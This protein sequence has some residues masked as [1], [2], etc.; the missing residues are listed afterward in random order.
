VM[1]RGR[2]QFVEHARVDRRG[3]GEHLARDHLS[4]SVTPG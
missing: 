4:A 3:V 1:P 2:D